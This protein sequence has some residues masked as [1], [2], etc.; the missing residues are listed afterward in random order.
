MTEKVA[1]PDYPF[2]AWDVLNDRVPQALDPETVDRMV[3]RLATGARRLA[4]PI[5]FGRGKLKTYDDSIWEVTLRVPPYTQGIGLFARGL[6]S[7]DADNP[8]ANVALYYRYQGDAWER[9]LVFDQNAHGWGTQD[10]WTA[11]QR[12]FVWS[13]PTADPSSTAVIKSPLPVTAS[14]EA[15]DVVI[16]MKIDTDL[17]FQLYE[18]GFFLLPYDGE[19]YP[20]VP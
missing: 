5:S 9:Y 2:D 8:N 14:D 17:T 7:L 1:S 18:Y 10:Y 15:H 16:E 4:Y 20:T 6:C 13:E 11:L 19:P 3:D 12:E